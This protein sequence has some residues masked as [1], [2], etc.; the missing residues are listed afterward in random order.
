MWLGPRGVLST[1]LA[2]ESDLGKFTLISSGND[3]KLYFVDDMS[4]TNKIH[5]VMSVPDCHCIGTTDIQKINQIDYMAFTDYVFSFASYVNDGNFYDRLP[6]SLSTEDVQKKTSLAFNQVGSA[7]GNDTA[8]RHVHFY[9]RIEGLV[10]AQGIRDFREHSHVR[11]HSKKLYETDKSGGFLFT[12]GVVYMRPCTLWP[13]YMPWLLDSYGDE[14]HLFKYT[15]PL[16]FSE[17]RDIPYFDM[18]D[19]SLFN[20]IVEQMKTDLIITQKHLDNLADNTGAVFYTNSFSFQAIFIPHRFTAEFLRLITPF[21]TTRLSPYVYVPFVFQ[22]MWD[23][24]EWLRMGYNNETMMAVPGKLLT[25]CDGHTV[26]DTM[27]NVNDDM[28]M[29]MYY[30]AYYCGSYVDIAYIV[31]NA[32]NYILLNLYM[33][34]FYLVV[35]FVLLCLCL[36]YMRTF[37]S[38]MGRIYACVKQGFKKVCPRCFGYTKLRYESADHSHDMYDLPSRDPANEI[39]PADGGLDL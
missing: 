30:F 22:L 23:K 27:R 14:H 36:R 5:W 31:H 11:K 18:A 28:A 10:I 6:C 17:V 24:N 33:V 16:V 20:L 15:Q 1:I 3:A 13:W 32:K 12:Q 39:I 25:S 29:G 8:F 26:E 7:S 21:A 35:A 19:A 38:C 2:S 34:T 4:M 37:C 9:P